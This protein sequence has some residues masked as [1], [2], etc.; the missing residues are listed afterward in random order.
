MIAW[1]VVVAGGGGT[2]F[3]R[4]KQFEM[5]RGRR[6]LDWSVAALSSA[7][8]GVVVVLP[9]G[10]VAQTEL[11]AGVAA[12]AGGANRSDSVRAGLAAIDPDATHVLVHDAAR[13]L[14]SEAVID[15][16]IAALAA[17]AR[18]VVPVVPVVDSLRSRD[19]HPVD[20][21]QL[22]AVQTPQGFEV[23]VL[24]L[25]HSQAATASDDASLV[26]QL[27][28]TVTHV[29]GEPINMKIT[30]PHDLRIAEVL[31]DGV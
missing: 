29:E 21:S 16:V 5:L 24:R 4:P 30:E 23:G 18:A 26:D 8:Q 2:R 14:V 12:V 13:P 6:V 17:G 1:G 22:V 31:L 25:A 10:I 7:C 15:R 28:L 19:G 20:R 27:G 9:A 3:G 11:P